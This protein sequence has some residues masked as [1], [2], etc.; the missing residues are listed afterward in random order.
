VAK[1]ITCD[2]CRDEEAEIMYS[3]FTDGTTLAVGPLCAPQFV[4]GLAIALGIVADPSDAPVDAPV[5]A[6]KRSRRKSEAAIEVPAQPAESDAE[7][8]AQPA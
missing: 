4:Y 1:S 6:P 8:L 5:D 7:Q 2:L 3:T